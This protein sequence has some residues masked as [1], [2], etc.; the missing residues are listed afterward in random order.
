METTSLR[1]GLEEGL[2]RHCLSTPG[3]YV[4]SEVSPPH[5]VT[6]P[7][8]KDPPLLLSSAVQNYWRLHV[9]SPST[10]TGKDGAM[11][12]RRKVRSLM[13][14]GSITSHL[15]VFFC[16]QAVGSSAPTVTTGLG[17]TG[18]RPDIRH[19]SAWRAVQSTEHAGCSLEPPGHWSET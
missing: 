19:M 6:N 16:S 14:A 12:R 8:W 1:E 17:E 4:S 10:S 13:A 2:R 18:S 11:R 5:N 3:H 15:C 7:P 9:W